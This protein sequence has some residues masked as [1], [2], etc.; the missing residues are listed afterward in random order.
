MNFKR[1]IKIFRDA[2]TMINKGRETFRYDTFG[3]ESFW[4]DGI[5]L[6]LAIAGK[7]F[8]GVG[9]GLSPKDALALGLKIDVKALPRCLRKAIRRG[10][11]DLN[12]PATTLALL[13]HDAVVGLTG[14]FDDTDKIKSVGIQCALCHSVVDDSF[15]LGL[16]DAWMDGQIET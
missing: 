11:I 2:L 10:E 7:R 8:G 1:A 16:V 3:D 6:H 9:S 13:K 4:G 14:F 12:D 5:G 15:A